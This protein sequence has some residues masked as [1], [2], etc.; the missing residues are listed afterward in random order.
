MQLADQPRMNI[1]S[2]TA[3]LKDYSKIPQLKTERDR[4]RKYI[5]Q[6]T[7]DRALLPPLSLEELTYHADVFIKRQSLN[8]HYRDF[9]TVLTGNAVWEST[10]GS[11]PYN[12]RILLLPQCLRKKDFCPA[13]LDEFGLLCEQCGGCPTGALQAEAEELGYLVLIAEG[14][15]VVTKLLETG[16][17]DGIIGVSCLTSLER[18]FPYMAAAAIP[19]LAIP[20]V[21][22]GCDNTQVD[23]DWV[24]EA[25]NLKSGKNWTGRFSLDKLKTEVNSWFTKENLSPILEFNNTTTERI[26]CEWMVKGGKRWRPFL[27]V[28]VFKAINGPENDIR[29]TMKKLAIAVECFH[30]ASLVHD[31]IEDNDDFR[32][33]TLTL[34]KKHGLPIALNIGD[35]LLG[36]GYRL[37]AE[38][39][40]SPEQKS[41]MLSAAA[42]GHRDLCLGQGEELNWM[43]NPVLLSTQKVLNIFR[44]K[45]VPAFEVALTLGAICAGGNGQ[46][47]NILKKFSESLGIA[48]QIWDDIEDFQGNGTDSDFKTLRP[49]LLLALALEN[50]RSNQLHPIISQHELKIENQHIIR[51]IVK[52]LQL[53]EKAWQMFEFHK[54]EAI[55]SLKPLQNYHLKSLLFRIIHKILGNTQDLPILQNGVLEKK[56]TELPIP[57]I[58]FPYKVERVVSINGV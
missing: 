56:E 58:N 10:V 37:I 22:E 32:Y 51:E 4:I 45:T 39:E 36:E 42:R 19:G 49:S 35:L 1:V 31:D 17:V 12:R 33:G 48:Y 52:E 40:V 18:S 23:L 16:Q 46:I 41:R 24:R 47:C 57:D 55:R 30:K 2:G 9:I 21:I 3:S 53:E 26:A 43:R 7:N 25:I 34:H 44:H 14:T 5:K 15:T 20:L 11:V 54:N 29:E 8:L 38:C 6:Y 50:D 28:S 27:A 13:E